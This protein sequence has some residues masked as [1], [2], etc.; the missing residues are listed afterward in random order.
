[1]RVGSHNNTYRI[2]SNRSRTPISSVG[3]QLWTVEVVRD[4]NSGFVYA[5][6]FE[7]NSCNREFICLLD[8]RLPC[9]SLVSAGLY[10]RQGCT[11]D[12]IGDRYHLLSTAHCL[13]IVPM[14]TDRRLL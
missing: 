7:Q 14:S 9:I 10:E 8:D 4:C 6:K 5:M 2:Y 11:H 3:H 12:F 1:M 13:V